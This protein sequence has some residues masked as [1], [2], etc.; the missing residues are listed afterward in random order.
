MTLDNFIHLS[1]A[2]SILGV[3][4]RILRKFDRVLDVLQEYPPHRHSNGKIVYPKHFS[5]SV[6]ESRHSQE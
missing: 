6:V 4:W 5:P 1:E 3:G 2:L